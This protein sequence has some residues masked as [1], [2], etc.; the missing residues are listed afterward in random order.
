MA[1]TENNTPSWMWETIATDRMLRRI[2]KK[3]EMFNLIVKAME[4]DDR[5]VFGDKTGVEETSLERS[6]ET[7]QVFRADD[8]SKQE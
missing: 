7:V 1:L 8:E 5:N 3:K 6:P 4:E 2:E